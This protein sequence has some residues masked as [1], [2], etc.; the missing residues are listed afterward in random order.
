MYEVVTCYFFFNYAR[1]R[2]TINN[3]SDEQIET[4]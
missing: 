3:E 4:L 2:S 1:V